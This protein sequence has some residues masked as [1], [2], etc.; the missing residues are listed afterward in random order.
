MVQI[1]I[2][3]DDPTIKPR[4][5]GTIFLLVRRQLSLVLATGNLGVQG[6]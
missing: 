4:P 6:C 3:T 5:V 2:T 1:S